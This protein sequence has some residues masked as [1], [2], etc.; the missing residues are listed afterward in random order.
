MR[1]KFMAYSVIVL[2]LCSLGSWW[3]MASRAMGG[4]GTGNSWHSG[5]SGPGY[6]GG[7][8]ATGGGGGHK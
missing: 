1:N 3:G 2:L 7:G 6:Y 5:M 8:W 4:Q